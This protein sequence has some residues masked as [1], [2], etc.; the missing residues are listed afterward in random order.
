MPNVNKQIKFFI[1]TISLLCG[2]SH[3][4]AADK[5]DEYALMKQQKFDVLFKRSRQVLIGHFDMGDI[6]VSQLNIDEPVEMPFIIE[7]NIKWEDSSIQSF[8][9]PV[10]YK[11]F[12]LGTKKRRDKFDAEAQ[13]Q[14]VQFHMK[15]GEYSR[16]EISEAEWQKIKGE[17]RDY[18]LSRRSQIVFYNHTR[19][20]PQESFNSSVKYAMFIDRPLDS[21][22]L[23]W[24]IIF[25]YRT[26]PLG[27]GMFADLLLDVE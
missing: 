25:P 4:S 18:N 20:G 2:A 3:I 14:A 26:I 17:D 22:T 12:L 8:I 13:K 11:V 15:A 24:E 5:S 19:N 9:V 16:G 23:N 10:P 27:W 6:N 21:K 7:K 1:V